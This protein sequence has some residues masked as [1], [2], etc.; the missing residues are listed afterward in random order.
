MQREFHNAWL[1]VALCW[2]GA[3]VSAPAM[4]QTTTVAGTTPGQFSVN[5]SGAAT[6]RIP[7]QVPP[8]VAGME[9]KLELSYNSQGGNGLLGMG[10]SLSGLSTISSLPPNHGP[11]RCQGAASTTT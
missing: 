9:P 4:A 5:E 8:G 3:V 11:G 1:S 7:I 6:Y 10:W 2:F